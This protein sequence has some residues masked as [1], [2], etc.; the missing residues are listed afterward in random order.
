MD[1][2]E[3]PHTKQDVSPTFVWWAETLR[4]HC[5]NALVL[6]FSPRPQAAAENDCDVRPWLGLASHTAA[7]QNPLLGSN[8]PRFN[9]QSME[10]KLDPKTKNLP[11]LR[12]PDILVGEND[13]TALSY[14]H[15]PAVLHNLKVR[16]VDSKLI[17]TY[18]GRWPA[19]LSVQCETT[20]K[21]SPK[22]KKPWTVCCRIFW[23]DCQTV[24][25][26]P[27]QL[28]HFLQQTNLN[29][30]FKSVLLAVNATSCGSL[31]LRKTNHWPIIKLYWCLNLLIFWTDTPFLM[32]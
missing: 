28:L 31:W 21:C 24:S 14:L 32:N 20:S 7:A 2:T 13:L 10:H 8:S 15:E 12:N 11:Y 19:A 30:V 1:L 4:P 23:I 27:L 17:Y 3:P 16:F 9:L 5:N 25:K 26:E 22:E 18:C 29:N 6:Y